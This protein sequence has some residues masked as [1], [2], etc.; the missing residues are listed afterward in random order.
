MFT[1]DGEVFL[2]ELHSRSSWPT[3]S[4]CSCSPPF[5]SCSNTSTPYFHVLTFP[6]RDVFIHSDRPHH[7]SYFFVFEVHDAC[8]QHGPGIQ[9]AGT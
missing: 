9:G 5:A 8:E 4:L 7:D 1:C 2:C 3:L 6:F